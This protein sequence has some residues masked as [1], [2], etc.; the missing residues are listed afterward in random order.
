MTDMNPMMNRRA[1]LGLGAVALA[2]PCVARAAA[3]VGA[4]TDPNLTAFLSDIHVSGPDQ[5]TVWGVQPTYQNAKFEQA[6]DEVLALSPRP[7]RVVVFGDVSLWFGYA[8]DYAAAQP[9]FKR[10]ADA[11]IEIFVTTGNHDH[12]ETMFAAFPK[13]KAI[14]PVP[15]RFVSVIDIGTADLVL[16][17]TLDETAK[18][19]GDPNRVGGAMDDAQFAWLER[20]AKA[21]KRPFFVG[22][23]HAPNDLNG[24][25]MRAMLAPIANFAGWIHGHDHNWSVDWFM[26][27]YASRRI[28]RVAALPSTGW[29]GDIGFALMRTYPDRAELELK[30]REF[31]FPGPL[32]A[33]EKA[34]AFWDDILREKRGSRCT[35]RYVKGD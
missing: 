10:L 35:F 31:Y 11:G 13:Q 6:V 27:S 24:R 29:W 28:C 30:V 2:A 17:D 25:K 23:H 32:A 22:A 7:A 12:R 5:K 1:F 21:R 20:E 4:K 33:G 9:A 16:M 3:T 19:L 15:G 18:K 34:P 8:G 14:T 26:E